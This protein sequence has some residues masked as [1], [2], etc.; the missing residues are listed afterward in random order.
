MDLRAIG[1]GGMGCIDLTNWKAL[2]NM[3]INPLEIFK[4][5]SDWQ[6]LKKDVAPWS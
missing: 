2:V 1:W 4:W 5:L 6:L 3:V